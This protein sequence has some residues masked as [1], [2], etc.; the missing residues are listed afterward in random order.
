MPLTSEQAKANGALGGR[1]PGHKTQKTLEREAIMDK[2]RDRTAKVANKLFNAQL[3]IATGQS[4]LFMIKTV[5]KKR[6]KPVLITDE[7][8]IEQYLDG[9]LDNMEDE[10]YYITT[11]EPVNQAIDS[12]YD[13]TFGRVTQSMDLTSGGEPLP[14]LYALSNNDS[15]K[16]APQADKKD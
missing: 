4:F 12:M 13:R 3:S 6:E 14:L 7:K 11:K 1:P 10:F 16:E 8:V 9:E 5:N 2:I 15:N